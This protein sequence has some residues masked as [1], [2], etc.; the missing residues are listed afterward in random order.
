MKTKWLFILSAIGLLG[1]CYLA[2]F[3]TIT[4]AAQ[5]PLF[6]PAASPYDDGIYAEGIVEGVQTSGE[7]INI[8]PEVPGTVKQLFVAEGQIVKKND[9]LVLI[10][11]SV[12]RATAEQQ[13]AQAQAAHALLEE[14]KAEPRQETLAITTAQVH[15]A[16]A[17]LKTA[18]DALEKEQA[19]YNVDQGSISKDA[20][21]GAVNTHALAEMNLEVAQRQNDLSRAGAWK[22]D[23]DNQQKQYTALIKSYASSEALLHKYLL[24]APQDGVVLSVNTIAGSFVSSQGTYDTYTQGADPIISLGSVGERLN[25]RCYVDEIL[26]S[27][28]PPTGQIKA[29][30]T[31]RGTTTEVPLTFDRIQPFISPKIELSNQRQERV[32][33]RVLPIIFQFERPQ[34]VPLY[35]GELVDVYIGH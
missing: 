11:D 8:Y 34:N 1:A 4:R 28:L 18:S 22:Y 21:D 12:Q 27:H 16:E 24:R 35:P 15:A 32:D 25:V 31:I 17:S 3:A 7:N 9:P 26:V 30:M 5:K 10:D 33:V 13:L 20:L 14:L 2:Y 19:A 23:I 6:N 29:R